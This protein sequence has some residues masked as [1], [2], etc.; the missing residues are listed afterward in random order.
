MSSEWMGRYR[1]L[2]AQLVRHGN[3]AVKALKHR[4]A[5]A[6]GVLLSSTE[7]QVLETV[8]EHELQVTNMNR[9]AEGI[10]IPQS[11]FSKTVTYLCGQGLVEKYQTANNKKNVI[12]RPTELALKVYESQSRVLEEHVFAP[13]F[14]ELEDVGD[15]ELEAMTRALE[16]LNCGMDTE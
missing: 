8:I 9:L 11:T 6:P 4:D 5:L 1:P 7:W 14:R 15:R 3:L 10:G 2:V 16:R 12:L 13:F